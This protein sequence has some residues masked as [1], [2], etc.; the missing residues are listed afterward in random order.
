MA[1]SN[2]VHFFFLSVYL[3]FIL[4]VLKRFSIRL[5]F[6]L[7]LVFFFGPM[8]NYFSFADMTL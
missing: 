1:L 8:S 4:V 2:L 6:I 5:D 7:V 3:G